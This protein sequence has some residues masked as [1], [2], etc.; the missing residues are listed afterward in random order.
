MGFDAVLLAR[1]QFAFTISFHIIF[2]TFTIGLSAWI[3]TL[4]VVWRR[5]GIE[6]YRDAGAVLDAHLRR[7]LRHGRGFRHR[8]LLRVRHQLEPLLGGRRQRRRPAHRLRGADRLL[9]RGDVPR[10]DAVRL[11]PGA[12]LAACDSQRCSSPLAPLLRLL[13]HFGQF[14]DAVSRPA[15]SSA[16]ASP[17]R[18]TGLRRSSPRPSRSASP[19]W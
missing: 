5:T 4:L 7:L 2:P 17:I 14:V 1:L 11:E 16:T 10:R 12:A 18:P 13:D 8:A 9:P 3:A 6:R 19:T 15:T